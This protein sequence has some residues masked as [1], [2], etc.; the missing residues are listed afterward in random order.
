M[1]ASNRPRPDEF[2]IL[3]LDGGGIK[4]T[5]T[6][7]VLA[8]WQ[9]LT[10]KPI[11]QHF[12]LITGTSTGGII[13]IALGL[14]LAPERILRLYVEKGRDIF[15]ASWHRRIWHW[16][17]RKHS[18]DALQ[19]ELQAA[20]GDKRF[21]DSTSRL[22]IPAF[23]AQHGG[24]H[25]FKTPHHVEYRMD[26]RHLATTVALSTAAAPTYFSAYEA[27]G[28]GCYIDGG[29]WANCPALVGIIEAVSKLRIPLE[30]IRLLSIGSTT[31]PYSVGSWLREGGLLLWARKVAPLLLQAQ[32]AGIVGECRVLL[33]KERFR[34]ID[35]VVEAGR[36]TLDRA[37][38]ATELRD[39]GEDS[40]RTTVDDVEREFLYAP[41]APFAPAFDTR[42]DVQADMPH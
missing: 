31:E 18:R 12:D 38:D 26:H 39:L 22:V 35:R 13:A 32:T 28:G 6:A 40:A 11:A 42:F 16:L 2:R 15:P 7:S 37:S 14:G 8:T 23:G 29:V 1:T 10:D 33:G 27:P 30:R 41:A 24:V 20:F 21:G 36:F 17:F 3:A 34:R 4:G 9:K 5:Y 19:R 25:L